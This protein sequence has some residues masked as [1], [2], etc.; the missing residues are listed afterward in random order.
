MDVDGD[1]N[2]AAKDGVND[3]KVEFVMRITEHGNA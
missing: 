1:V 3:R 2:K